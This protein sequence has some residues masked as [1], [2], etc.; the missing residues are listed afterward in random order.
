MNIKIFPW[1]E[2]DIKTMRSDGEN[3][4]ISASLAEAEET[5]IFRFKKETNLKE[6]YDEIFKTLK[7]FKNE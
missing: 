1:K 6:V 5:K 2:L 7:S 3:I 4:I